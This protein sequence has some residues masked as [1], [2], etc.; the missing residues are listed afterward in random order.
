MQQEQILERQE[1]ELGAIGKSVD[2]LGEMGRVINS[3]LKS[4]G[5]ELDAFTEEVRG[6]VLASCLSRAGAMRAAPG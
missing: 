6:N 2:R 3:E 1:V 5:R 4:Q